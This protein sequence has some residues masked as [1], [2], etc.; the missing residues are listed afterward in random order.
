[1]IGGAERDAPGGEQPRQLTRFLVET[2][3]FERLPGFPQFSFV[4]GVGVA[5]APRAQRPQRALRALAA[6]D[7]R[8]PEEHNSVL[9]P[10]LLEAAER[11][12]IFGDDPDGARFLTVE[13]LRIH[14]RERRLR[15]KRSMYH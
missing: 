15:H 6:V 10:L 13:E 14:V 8:R 11:F 7:A 9:N 3:P 2:R 1:M 12:E 4:R 5:F